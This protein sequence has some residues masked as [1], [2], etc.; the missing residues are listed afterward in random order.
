[1]LDL[2]PAPTGP[3]FLNQAIELGYRSMVEEAPKPRLQISLSPSFRDALATA[4]GRPEF[5]VRTA[6]E[7]PETL[8][9]ERWSILCDRV[10]SWHGQ[11]PEQR[12]RVCW[13]LAELGLYEDILNL[14]HHIP[15]ADVERDEASAALVYLRAWARSKKWLDNAEDGFSADEFAPIALHAP[16]GTTRI[17]AAYE[18]VRQNAKHRGDAAECARWQ[19]VHLAAIESATG[20]DEHTRTL[21]LSRY[22]RVGAFIPQFRGDAAAVATD[23]ALAE[24]LARS[25][26]RDDPDRAAAADEMLYAAL[27]SRIREALWLRDTATALDRADEYIA[28]SP[29][30][31]RGYMHRAEV[32]FSAGEWTRCRSDCLEAY[33]LAPPHADEAMFLAGQCYEHE[34]SPDEAIGAYLS[35]LR[36]DPLAI[37]AVE[38]LTDLARDIGMGEAAMLLASTL[39]HR[40]SVIAGRRKWT[41]QIEQNALLAGMDRHLASVRE[42]NMTVPEALA[43][44]DAFLARVRAAAR[45][46]VDRDGAEVIVLSEIA[47][48]GFARALRA[49]LGVAFVDPGMA[50]WKWAE[51]M[52]G[53]YER[54]SLSHS[55]IGAYERPPEI[56]SRPGSGR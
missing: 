28:L 33:R 9:T 7:L 14:V 10:E 44:P 29:S 23:M 21:M 32:L 35:V 43:D 56:S 52:A 3:T 11:R 36:T 40:F 30:G 50:A 42:V 5:A 34:D 55:E 37:S 54:E 15:A 39:G 17:D 13:A 8:R 22:H 18:M 53:L 45:L 48:P 2:G 41:A 4:V 16:P 25:A 49:E 12:V 19:T 24:D 20:L 27:E 46:A 51:M 38:R 6:A 31:A 26:A 47:P 1:M